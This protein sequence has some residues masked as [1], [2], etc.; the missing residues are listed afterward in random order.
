MSNIIRRKPDAGD[1]IIDLLDD[2]YM[3]V[4]I[5]ADDDGRRQGFVFRPDGRD[6]A[7]LVFALEMGHLSGDD[8]T[9]IP[10]HV[11]NDLAKY[12]DEHS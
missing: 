12:E 6:S 8:E 3:S 4:P 7:S 1:E 11:L 5:N 9:P 2:W 10:R